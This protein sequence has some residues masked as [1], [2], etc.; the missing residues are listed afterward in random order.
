MHYL[1][2]VETFPIN[3]FL[4]ACI[5][6]I[7]PLWKKFPSGYFCSYSVSCSVQ[8][9]GCQPFER[10]LTEESFHANTELLAQPNCTERLYSAHYASL[11]CK[12]R[13]TAQLYSTLCSLYSRNTH[14][15]DLTLDTT[16]GRNYTLDSEGFIIQYTVCRLHCEV[17]RVQCGVWSIKSDWHSVYFNMW[18]VQL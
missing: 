17:Y 3:I 6:K 18:S 4:Y 14:W 9:T 1:S 16:A 5:G 7:S 2:I 13:F 10:Y 12:L 15:R 8:S 11:H